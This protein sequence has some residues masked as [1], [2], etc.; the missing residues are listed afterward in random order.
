MGPLEPSQWEGVGV[1]TVVLVLM[2][3]HGLAVSRGWIVWG[4]SHREQIAGKDAEIEHLRGRS[5]ED[6]RTISTQA[7][8]ISKATSAMAEQTVASQYAVHILEAVR[9]VTGQA[10]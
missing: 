10:T 5:L 4:P 7:E 8:A 1:G 3:C 6:Q 2:L 9:N